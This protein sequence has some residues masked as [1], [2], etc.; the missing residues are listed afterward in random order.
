MTDRGKRPKGGLEAATIRSSYKNSLRICFVILFLLLALPAAWR[1]TS[2]NPWL[3]LEKVIVFQEAAR[4]FPAAFIFIWVTGIYLVA[5]AMF[6]PVT[7]LNVA[8]VLTFGPLWGNAYALAGWLFSST[9]G[10]VIGRIF[11]RNLLHTIAGAR[12]DR[13]IQQVRSRGFVAVLTIRVLP[14]APFTLANLGVGASGIRFRDFFLASVV[15]RIPGILVLSVAGVHLEDALRNQS[16]G[17]FILLGIVLL[18][19]PVMS[20]W[21]SKRFATLQNRQRMSPGN[22]SM[23]TASE[24]QSISFIGNEKSSKNFSVKPRE[25]HSS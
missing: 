15:G 22:E 13:F 2:L 5:T 16:M 24:N 19:I 18:L 4:R 1:W 25:S 3:D 14:V 10:F 9:V 17:S 21:L 8:T 7:M 23:P 12:L 11:G 6:F 20:V